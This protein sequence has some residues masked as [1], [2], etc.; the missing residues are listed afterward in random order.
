[1]ARHRGGGS[2]GG[3]DG[4][5]GE[6]VWLPGG[7]A[8]QDDDDQ[9]DTGD[10]LADPYRATRTSPGQDAQTFAVPENPG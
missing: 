3:S 9:R 4:G 8:G 6:G 7:Y 2:S 10:A 1:M 5:Y